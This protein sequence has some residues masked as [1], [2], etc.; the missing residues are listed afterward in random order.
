M[1]ENWVIWFSLIVEEVQNTF[2]LN[3]PYGKNCFS[4]IMK[5]YNKVN[6]Y[7]KNSTLDVRNLKN[8]KRVFSIYKKTSSV[9][10]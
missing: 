10:W 6:N 1:N 8:R 9:Q 3:N 7:E 2:F 4:R 5:K